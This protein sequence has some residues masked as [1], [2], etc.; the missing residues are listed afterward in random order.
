MMMPGL[1][2]FLYKKPQCLITFEVA[3]RL[4]IPTKPFD[5]H[6]PFTNRGFHYARR[7]AV[8]PFFDSTA[9]QKSYFHNIVFP[10][11]FPRAASYI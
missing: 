9:K 10:H 4:P 7:K 1:D 2:A 11:F 6:A 8:P 3:P 5:S